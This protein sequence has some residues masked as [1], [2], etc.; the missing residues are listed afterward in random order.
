MRVLETVHNT[1]A[2]P[3]GAKKEKGMR[4]HGL[5]LAVGLA[6]AAGFGLS[7]CS[8]Q[9]TAEKAGQQIDQ[10]M[11][12]AK[13]KAAA[14]EEKAKAEAG[15]AEEKAAQEAKAAKEATGEA[16]SAAG[17]KAAGAAEATKEAAGQA[18]E[19][20]KEAAGSAAGAAMDA[21]QGSPEKNQ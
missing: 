13:D 5:G 10:G 12:Q 14:A 8:D 17:E 3:E 11:Q 7:S 21:A 20:A 1:S 9:G 2:P 15:A 16:A 19:A 6:A 4:L 18:A